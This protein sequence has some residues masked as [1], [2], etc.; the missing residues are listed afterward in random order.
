MRIFAFIFIII[1]L[2]NNAQE[3]VK[4][5]RKK[6]GTY[7]QPHRRTDKNKTEKDNYSSKPNYNPYTGKKGTKTPKK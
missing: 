6:N 7:V 1:S 4:G 5:Y 3:R 2:N